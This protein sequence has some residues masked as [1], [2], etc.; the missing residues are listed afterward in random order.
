M[1]L[2]VQPDD[3]TAP[4]LKG[5]TAAKESIEVVIF[6]ADQRELEQALAKAVTRG[7]AVRA[8]I[9]HTNRSAEEAL[10]RLEMR[11]LAAGA[12]VARTAD[13]LVRYHAKFMIIDHRELYLLGFNFTSLDMD[14]SRSFG[15]VTRSR[16]LVREAVKL[17]EADT[18]R[19]PYEPGSDRF[20]VSPMNAR[21]E[22]FRF[23]KRAKKELLIYD[24]K[25][26]DPDMIRLLQD[27]AKAGVAIKVIGRLTRKTE[28]VNVRKL[29]AIRL[30]ARTMVRDRHAAFIGSQSLRELELD[31]RR[32]VGII[33]RDA[34]AVSRIVQTF[35]ADW[36]NA[37][38]AKEF[39]T[40]EVQKPAAK[41]ARKV[42]KA[43]ARELPPLAPALNGAVEQVVGKPKNG[44]L[45]IAEVEE[46]VKEAVKHAVKDAV[47]NV[48][49][50]VVEQKTERVE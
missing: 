45:D 37:S 44:K 9:A 33:F 43:V 36:A 3:G 13:D 15:V 49:E 26:S 41:V 28:G 27:R 29:A 10:R 20:V 40:A 8:L 34:K 21:K 4:L 46:A 48:V 18:S 16:D 32:E 6:R 39:E 2:L 14:H 7:I 25:L 23:I 24:L 31:A 1:R 47:R 38:P 50:G 35:E 42:A 11:L 5:I 19:Q 22:L 12:T 30:H 17:F